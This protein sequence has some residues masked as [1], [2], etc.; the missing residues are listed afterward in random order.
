MKSEY[1]YTI[2]YLKDVTDDKFMVRMIDKLYSCVSE[3]QVM[4]FH[5]NE[6]N[7]LGCLI[8]KLKRLHKGEMFEANG[9]RIVYEEPPTIC[10]V[11]IRNI[12]EH[13]I[14]PQRYSLYLEA[15]NE[16][17]SDK[18]F[19]MEEI[20]RCILL[21]KEYKDVYYKLLRLQWLKDDLPGHRE[22]IQNGKGNP[23]ARFDVQRSKQR[24][25]Q[26]K[27]K[28]SKYSKIK[29]KHDALK[30]E[31][32][33]QDKKATTWSQITTDNYNELRQILYKENVDEG[34]EWLVKEQMLNG[35]EAAVRKREKAVLE[36][37][38]LL[39]QL[40]ALTRERDALVK[41]RKEAVR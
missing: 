6:L 25:R 26:W 31:L 22:T 7:K 32:Q 39:R 34:L 29:K 3:K 24:L 33:E 15:L 38:E 19:M 11:Y 41:E 28:R 14:N 5:E 4:D 40:E 1:E 12:Y 9:C 21:Q 27:R 35:Q 13:T 23:D 30:E 2:G 16:L 8:K 37:E 20:E 36:R 10:K 18:L 17:C